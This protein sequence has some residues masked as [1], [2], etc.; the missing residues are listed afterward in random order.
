MKD[1]I[2]INHNSFNTLILCSF[3]YALGRNTYICSEI[4]ELITSY[5]PELEAYVKQIMLREIIMALEQGQAGMDCDARE[6]RYLL[7][8]LEERK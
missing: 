7:T 6:W 3:R 4:V 8:V 5:L 1:K 2:K